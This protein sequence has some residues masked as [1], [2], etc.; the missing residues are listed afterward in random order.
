MAPRRTVQDLP[1]DIKVF[2][3]LWQASNGFLTWTQV[4]TALESVR[5]DVTERL[6]ARMGYGPRRGERR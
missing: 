4:L 1:E 6:I 3:D 2:L 5:Y